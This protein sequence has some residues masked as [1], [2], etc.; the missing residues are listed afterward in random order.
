[1]A[2]PLFTLNAS[3]QST[4]SVNASGLIAGN[5]ILNTSNNNKVTTINFIKK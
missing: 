5:Y 3:Q 1:M 4:Y 2:V